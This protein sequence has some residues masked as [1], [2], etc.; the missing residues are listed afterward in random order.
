MVAPAVADS[1]APGKPPQEPSSAGGAP[2][3]SPAQRKLDSHIVLA[4]RKSRGEPP[5]DKPT[6]LDPGLA[7][8]PDGRVLVDLDACVSKELLERIQA[9]GG[10][11]I[12]SF[13]SAH[14]IRA[15]VPL[16]EME[17]LAARPDIKFVAPA[18]QATS[19]TR[20]D[21]TRR[22]PGG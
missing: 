6:T 16:T 8:E 17:P 4:L 19:D 7:I 18:V 21:P 3:L 9:V 2:A 15:L 14:A 22:V 5:F 1:P 11:I 20:H 10:K 12:N 13:K